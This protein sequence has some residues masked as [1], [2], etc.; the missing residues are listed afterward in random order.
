MAP[1]GLL[2]CASALLA[3]ALAATPALAAWPG[4]NGRL[5]F[6]SVSEGGVELRTSTLEGRRQ[7]VL[8][9]FAPLPVALHQQSGAPQWSPSGRRLLFQRIASGL[10]IVGPSGRPRRTIET[11]L[12]FPGWA[13]GGRAFVAVD[14]SEVPRSLVLMRVDGEL[15]RRIAIP[16]A[17]HVLLPRW[18]PSGR[19][20]VYEQATE[21]GPFLWRVRPDGSAARRLGGGELATWAPGG[22]RLAFTDGRDV[23]SMRPDGGGRRRLSRGPDGT[24]VGG[25][26]W[27][28][29]GRRIAIVRQMHPDVDH[30][31]VVTTIPA[32]GGREK[33]RFGG[34]HFI[35]LI[36][37]QAR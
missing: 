5:A 15:Q 7:R 35:G 8:A 2:A 21:A 26:A 14:V 11:S 25:L 37:W 27:S 1:R 19:W 3:S 22:R 24:D 31:A 23:W 33:R 6:Q 34:R 30:S 28:P 29:D 17:E 13:P 20:I 16:P 36:D 10:E 4:Q 32:R 18:S 12:L 9:R